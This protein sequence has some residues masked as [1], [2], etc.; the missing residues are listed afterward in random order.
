[1]PRPRATITAVFLCGTAAC[2]LTAGEE[3]RASDAPPPG[4]RKQTVGTLELVGVF[5]RN[6]LRAPTSVA[7]S[8]DGKFL[9]VSGYQSATHLVFR[10]DAR[11]GN[12]EHVQTVADP[13]LLRGATALRLSPDGEL[14]AAAA[15]QSSAVVLYQRNP[16]SGKLTVL[17]SKTDKDLQKRWLGFAVDALFSPDGRFVYVV[18]SMGALVPFEITGEG[19]ERRLSLKTP[20]VSRD[21]ANMRGLALHPSGETV[22]AASAEADTLVVLS[23]DKDSGELKVRQVLRDGEGSVEGLEG[24]F[25][26]AVSPDGKFV[27]SVSGR[28]SGDTAIGTYRLQ[29][30]LGTL[31]PVQE[32]IRDAAGPDDPLRNFEGGNEIT[33]SPDGRNVYAVASRAGAVAAFSRDPG[34]GKVAL[35]EVVHDQGAVSGAAGVAVSP[36]GRFVYVASEFDDAISVFRR[37]TSDRHSAE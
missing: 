24:A 21:L 37:Q 15:F 2:L 22:V 12:L 20:L 26:V 33:V 30:P 18:N 36:D 32:I 16:G 35:L 4:S 14:A 17:D 6:D 23:R 28:F 31:T 27:Y 8:P 3:E 9:Y 13:V 10:Q 7:I 34:T 11:S 5:A 19:R 25:G 29:E 1:M